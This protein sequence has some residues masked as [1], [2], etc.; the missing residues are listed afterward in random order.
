MKVDVVQSNKVSRGR[1]SST[2]DISPNLKP[3]P[4][5]SQAGQIHVD[6]HPLRSYSNTFAPQLFS[7]DILRIHDS[8]MVGIGNQSHWWRRSLFLLCFIGLF[9]PVCT[10]AYV[11][12]CLLN[13]I[14]IT[15][16][17]HGKA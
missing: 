7:I 16:S 9:T 14:L 12:G 5:N 3:G 10:S 17:S 13:N 1:E 4:P 11:M 2:A 6:A 8:K 15:P